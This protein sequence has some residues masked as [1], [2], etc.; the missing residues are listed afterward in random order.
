VYKS[1]NPRCCHRHHQACMDKW[2]N[3]QNTC[4]VCNQP[5]VLQNGEDAVWTQHRQSAP[6]CRGGHLVLFAA[7][8]DFRMQWLQQVHSSYCI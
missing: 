3:I 5:Y 7:G 8:N 1:N 2:L 4:P 6:T